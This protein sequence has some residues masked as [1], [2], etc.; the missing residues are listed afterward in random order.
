MSEED[1][2]LILIKDNEEIDNIE[3]RN[4]HCLLSKNRVI[5]ICTLLIL[6]SLVITLILVFQKNNNPEPEP[7]TNNIKKKNLLYIVQDASYSLKQPYSNFILKSDGLKFDLLLKFLDFYSFFNRTDVYATLLGTQPEISY[8]LL[9]IFNDL[10]S[11]EQSDIKNKIEHYD[12]QNIY[13]CSNPDKDIKEY[14]NKYSINIDKF[15]SQTSKNKKCV[16]AFYLKDDYYLRQKV[17]ENLKEQNKNIKEHSWWDIFHLFDEEYIFKYPKDLF[18]ND[19]IED[20]TQLVIKETIDFDNHKNNTIH[21]ILYV[22]D[23]IKAVKNQ[24]EKKM[25]GDISINDILNLFKDNIYGESYL[26]ET[27]TKIKDEIIPIKNDYDNKII[28][29]ITDGKSADGSIRSIIEEIKKEVNAYIIVL[30]VSSHDLNRPK[31]LFNNLPDNLYDYEKDL[32]EASSSLNSNLEMFSYLNKQDII[33]PKNGQ[34]KLFFQGNDNYLINVLLKSL[35]NIFENHDLL[36]D[37]VGKVELRKYVGESIG[38]FSPKNQGKEGTC[39]AFASATAIHL[40]LVRLKGDKSPPFEDIK[41]YLINKYGK[42]GY[43]T[44]ALL[45]EELRQYKL[46]FKEVDEKGAREA[47]NKKRVCVVTFRYTNREYAKYRTFFEKRPKGILSKEI[48]DEIEPY[49]KYLDEN[50]N[51][52]NTEGHAVVLVSSQIEYLRLLNSWGIG[53]GDQ[54]F[55]KIKNSEVFREIHFYELYWD[56]NDLTQTELEEHYKFKKM[57]SVDYFNNKKNYEEICNYKVECPHCHEESRIKDFKGNLIQ[58]K[59]PIC[60]EYFDIKDE[61]LAQKLYFDFINL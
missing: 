54:G 18:I 8:D 33:I 47:V 59:C 17:Y 7:T 3:I 1:N 35:E 13:K 23:A 9:G 31:E 24:L 34:I 20:M 29:L 16:L 28:F 58:V 22:Y 19:I 56:D 46:S 53:F 32:F 41:Y 42:D 10:S 55:F 21:S 26:V 44:K 43:S 60:K 50:R 14:L 48:M 27:L 45:T 2:S 6:L 39:Y 30:F 15:L 5:L 12:E 11:I 40:T 36:L 51:N 57:L 52:N 37:V 25:Y 49:E 4:K 38:D 61:K